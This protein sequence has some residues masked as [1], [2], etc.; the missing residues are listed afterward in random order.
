MKFQENH[1]SGTK[2]SLSEL[3]VTRHT[4]DQDRARSIK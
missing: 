2:V 4:L 1:P 3:N